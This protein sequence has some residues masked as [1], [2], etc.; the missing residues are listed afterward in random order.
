[1]RWLLLVAFIIAQSWRAG[2]AEDCPYP[3]VCY[4]NQDPERTLTVDCRNQELFEIPLG[5][6]PT[7]SHLLAQITLHPVFC[8]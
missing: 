4:P 2:R 5:I 7:T 3:C 6:P 8:S 1:M